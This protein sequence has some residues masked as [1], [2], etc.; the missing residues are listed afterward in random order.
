[1]LLLIQIGLTIW[2]WTR[3]WKWWSLIPVAVPFTIGLIV[4]ASGGS[5]GGGMVTFDILA[6][7]ALIVMISVKK[8]VPP[9]E[10]P[11]V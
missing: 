3:G 10:E 4:G 6:V 5:Y 11:K 1:M 9:E 8:P 7:I 2:A